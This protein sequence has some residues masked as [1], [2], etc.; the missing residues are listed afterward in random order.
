MD[1]QQ[2]IRNFDE[3]YKTADKSSTLQFLDILKPADFRRTLKYFDRLY[4]NLKEKRYPN[5]LE[6]IQNISREL[7]QENFMTIYD[8]NYGQQCE[9]AIE[10]CWEFFKVAVLCHF[11]ISSLSCRSRKDETVL[12]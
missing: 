6:F 5:S 4:D 10:V 9:I 12:H 2:V 11:V 3:I 1:F 7:Q 8:V